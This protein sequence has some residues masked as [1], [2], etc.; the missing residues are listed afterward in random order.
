MRIDPVNQMGAVEVDVEAFAR[1]NE[2]E[3]LEIRLS[4]LILLKF[5]AAQKVN[6]C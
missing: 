6:I 3:I 2:L 5:N 1:T 4:R